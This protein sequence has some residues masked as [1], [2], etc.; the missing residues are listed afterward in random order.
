MLSSL[1]PAASNS[2]VVAHRSIYECEPRLCVLLSLPGITKCQAR[3]RFRTS[4]QRAC[5]SPTLKFPVSR[6]SPPFHVPHSGGCVGAD[7]ELHALVA[8]RVFRRQTP[9][10][11][12]T[13]VLHGATPWYTEH[14]GAEHGHR[15]GD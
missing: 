12:N 11:W 5:R 3:S 4:P 6:D 15:A 13:I 2:M 1:K 9:G 14:G 10:V 8:E 7:R